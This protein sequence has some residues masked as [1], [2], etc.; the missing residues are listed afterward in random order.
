MLMYR[1]PRASVL[2]FLFDYV[3]IYYSLLGL[4]LS[5]VVEVDGFFGGS[6]RDIMENGNLCGYVKVHYVGME[7]LM[8]N[9]Q[10]GFVNSS[11]NQ[12]SINSK[13]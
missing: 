13:F 4:R 11:N 2:I 7:G 10:A 9:G 8:G 5:P 12:C 1:A 6:R 3:H